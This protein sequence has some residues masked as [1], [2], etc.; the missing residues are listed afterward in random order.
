MSTAQAWQEKFNS[1][2][3]RTRDVAG[4]AEAVAQ[5]F[6]T[7]VADVIGLNSPSSGVASKE[8]GFDLNQFKAKLNDSGVLR[9]TLFLTSFSHSRNMF[10]AGATSADLDT[11]RLYNESFS[12]PG[13]SWITSDNIRRYGYGPVEARPYIPSFSDIVF[14]F[15]VDG[16]GA[17]FKYFY[18][19][20]TSTIP[21]NVKS[22]FNEGG[23]G[24]DRYTVSYKEDYV[25]DIELIV[26]NQSAQR[27]FVCKLRDA[28]PVAVDP[29]QMNWGA[30]DELARLAVT[31][32]FTDWSSA[33]FD[34]ADLEENNNLNFFQRL[35]QGASV[36]QTLSTITRPR[37]IGDIAQ[38][39]NDLSVIK[40][41]IDLF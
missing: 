25:T 31:F 27:V 13:V 8:G 34:I 29:I 37:S 40:S 32:K 26:F 23:P 39:V 22:S 10:K 4:T 35:Q 2:L 33:S 7:S 16:K 41:G 30:T 6:G 11:V 9:P 24:N 14:N 3:N 20:Q 19:W 38:V 21:F 12:L 36:L 15:I 17:L 28:W 5:L 18:Q 1:T